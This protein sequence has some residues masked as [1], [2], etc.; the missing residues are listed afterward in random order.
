ML[1]PAD[2]AAG[3][4][5][6]AAEWVRRPERGS[7]TLL[8]I[9][10]FVSLRLGRPL[11]RGILYVIAAYFFTFAPAAR[12][13]SRDYLRRALGREPGARDRYAQVF[14]FASTI[15][16]R[17]YLVNERYQLF[18]VSIEGE[19]LMREL[20]ARGQGAFLLGAHLGSFELMSTVGRRQPGLRVAMAMYEHQANAVAAMFGNPANAPEIIPIGH[21][22]AMLHIRDRL[23]QGHF[24]GI[25]ADRSPEQTPGH[26][27]NFLGRPALFPTGPMRVA[28]ALRRQVIFMTGLYRG[29]NRYHVVFRALAD[30]SQVARGARECAVHA[31]IAR[32]AAELETFCR[33][34]PYN[35]FNFYDFWQ[36][37][38]S[39]AAD[40]RRGPP[41][42]GAGA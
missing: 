19:E 34:D 42:G 31:A 41:A 3:R 15:L 20:F 8:K 12:R 16:D 4:A 35:W 29:G 36:G 32:Y 14:A 28:A 2:A 21:L 18:E 38:D 25:L 6:R 26:V 30:F 13:A 33:S 17:L 22:D 27:V 40:T 1:R 11:A 5:A 39:C 23:D 10:M 9:M 37:A 7:A 24:V